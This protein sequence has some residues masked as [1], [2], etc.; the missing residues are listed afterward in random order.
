METADG[1][2]DSVCPLDCPDTCSLSVTIADGRVTHVDGSHRNPYTAGFIC[3][4]VRRYPER[5]YAPERLL[6]PLRRVG[7][8]GE[9]RFARISWDDALDLVS[10][11]LATVVRESGA[12]AI[13][14]YH[15]GGSNGLLNDDAVD[16]RFFHLL[17]AS[18]LEKTIC[19]APTGAVAR[20]LYGGMVGVP[21]EDYGR[22]RCIVL[23]GVNPA[24]TSIHTLRHVQEAQRAGALIVVVDP[25]RTR[26][27]R[28]ADIHLQ[29]RPGTDVVL[30]LAVARQLIASGACDASFIAANVVG[31]ETFR[32][33]AE[34]FTPSVCEEITAVPVRDL[35]N[36]AAA[37]AAASPAVVRCGWGLERNRNGGNAVRAVL[38]LPAIAG[39][40]GVR[41]GGYTMSMSGGFDIDKQRLGRPDLRACP[42]R[43]VN[44]TQLGRALTE[45][46][47]P[48]IR[49]L[50]VYNANPVASTP[51]QNRVLAGLAREDLFTVV[52]EQV[53][54]D[55]ALYADVVLPATTIFE[56]N[57]LHKS[58]GHVY[59]Q[60]SRALID[61]VGEAVDNA[62][63]FRHLA[64][65]MGLGTADLFAEQEMMADAL[66]VARAEEVRSER[67][68][69]MAFA[70]SYDV[71]QFGTVWPRTADGKIHLA[72]ADLGPICF[73]EEV[74]S[75][76]PLVLLTPASERLIN[77]SLGE[78]NLADPRLTLHPEDASARGIVD[79]AAVRIYNDLGRVE[80]RAR[81]ADDVAPGVVSMPKGIWRS[82]TLNG[83][84]ATALIADDLGDIGDGACFNDARVEVEPLGA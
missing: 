61:P 39:K 42:A 69:R 13:L 71:V 16:A 82:A 9:G 59:L 46:A 27:A 20:A 41:G 57:E 34:R 33:A 5:V 72:P 38:A 40:F 77:S 8:K 36:F 18:Q 30:A 73:R 2:Y 3:A 12:E 35:C 31:F 53:M 81:V 23:W 70:G 14:P 74:P 11:R 84:T 51:D 45:L 80:V 75:T 10:S 58:Y 25:R 63:L 17:G 68:L 65:R 60:Y 44:M 76:Y 19:A 24:A 64:A 50:F 22:A 79:G 62:T 49:A 56:Q 1:I 54:T 32:A 47:S 43:S 15:Y 6:H 78:F 55:T 29:P 66:G 21:P 28:I 48:P 67:V 26:T 4:K 52:H 7:A 83:A 37:Y